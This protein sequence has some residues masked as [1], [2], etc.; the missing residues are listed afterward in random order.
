[1]KDGA[2]IRVSGRGEAGLPGEGAGDLFVVVGVAPHPLF[3][4]KG[5]DLTLELPVSYPE[6]A[7]GADV[8]VPTL[9]G[10]VTLKVPAGTVNG[11]TFR[12]RGKGAPRPKGGT[13]D[14]LVTVRIDVPSKLSRE[15][16]D[17]LQQLQD[18]EAESPR[19]RLGM[20]G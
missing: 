1:V 19:A 20:E 18:V 13:G 9:N 16:R 2:R 10:G 12:V 5:G 8:R 7:L 15:Q 14:L 17:L 11:R 6:A 3:G 4:R